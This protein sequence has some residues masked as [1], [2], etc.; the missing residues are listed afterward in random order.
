MQRK[1]YPEFSW[2]LSR[3]KSMIDCARKYGLSYYA[4]HNGWFRDSSEFAKEAYRLK[5]ITNLPILFGQEV[6]DMIESVINHYLATSNIPDEDRLTTHIRNQLNRAF[7]DSVKG[8][9]DWFQRPNK[10]NMLH[11]IYY[12]GKLRQEAIEKIEERLDVC[13]TNFLNSDSFR[14]L[15]ERRSEIEFLESEQF[16]TM[17]IEGVKV[18]V[19]IDV[20]Y[21]DLINDKWVIVD[22]KT[23]KESLE[24]RHQL[25]IY[26]MYLSQK[27]GA[28]L[29]QIQLR[30]E[31]LLTGDCRVHEL[32]ESDLMNV[33]HIMKH[34]LVEMGKF[35][36]DEDENKPVDLSLFPKTE[37]IQKCDRCNFRQICERD[38]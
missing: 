1:P 33:Y 26:A 29:D 37:Y 11:E 20:L 31:Y 18:F 7:R 10:F 23:G 9:N 34:S 27:F 14:D 2:S 15:T 25:A 17:E 36:V 8:Y 12:G 16:R 21:K 35:L 32:N 4:S 3:H 28:R 6:H 5:K 19:V 24:D 38:D 22:W 13:I 30:N